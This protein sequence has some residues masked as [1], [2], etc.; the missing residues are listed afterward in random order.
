MSKRETFPS[1]TDEEAP[2]TAGTQA[3]KPRRPAT[4]ELAHRTGTGIEVSLL[5]RR[6][7]NSLTLQLVELENGV[8]FELSISPEDALD[9]FYHPY[10]YLPRHTVDP[11]QELLAA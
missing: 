7:D 2:M 8:V 11:W 9:A 6:S 10:A 5:W 4:R 1:L 3:R